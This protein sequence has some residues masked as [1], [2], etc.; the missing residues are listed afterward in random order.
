MTNVRPVKVISVTGGKGGVGKTSVTVNLAVAL[1]EQGHSV[2]L[3]DADLGLANIDVMLGLKPHKNLSHVLSGEA[4]INDIL[5]EGPG[6]IH[7][8]PASSGTQAM[9][10]LS[11][12]EH[13][14]LIQAFSQIGQ[15]IDYLII[16]TAAGISDTVVSFTQAS[17]DILFVVCDEP[18]SITDAYALM[19]V[20]NK[21]YRLNRFRVLANQVRSP[22]EG[23]EVFQRLARV[24]ER[25]LDV[26]LDYVGSVPFDEHLRKAIKKQR[27]VMEL[28]PRS[29]VSMALRQLAKKV[30]TWPLPV[31]PGG[32]IEFFMERLVQASLASGMTESV[33]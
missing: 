15:Q 31:A 4:E 16:D 25:F 24:C 3:M 7:I 5:V 19:K 9:S 28:F 13:A 23:R 8:V 32:H 6:G 2:M 11:P 21:D 22:A 20:L 26:T 14:G 33:T 29:P 18:T 27:A 10:Q 30:E 17:Q 1:A 12:A